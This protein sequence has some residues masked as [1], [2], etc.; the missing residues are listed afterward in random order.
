MH[1]KHSAARVLMVCSLWLLA[2]FSS[3]QAQNEIPRLYSIDPELRSPADAVLPIAQS[4]QEWN[5]TFDSEWIHDRAH[6]WSMSVPGSEGLL[7]EYRAR[8]IFYREY[9][10]GERQWIG[11]LRRAEEPMSENAVGTVVIHQVGGLPFG[12]IRTEHGAFDLYSDSVVGTRLARVGPWLDSGDVAH[13]GEVVPFERSAMGS[14]PKTLQEVSQVD[15]LV[16][17]DTELAANFVAIRNKIIVEKLN[18]DAVFALSG[19]PSSRGVPVSLNLVEIQTLAI[20]D[21]LEAIDQVGNTNPAFRELTN[22]TSAISLELESRLAQSGADLLALFVPFRPET[23]FVEFCGLAGVPEHG[24]QDLFFRNSFSMQS[25][26]CSASQLVFVHELLHNFGSNHE[27]GGAF[28][29]YAHGFSQQEAVA[30]VMGCGIADFPDPATTDCLRALRLSD[31]DDQLAGI[32]LGVPGVRDN[33][34]FLTECTGPEMCRRERVANRGTGTGTGNPPPMVGI[35]QPAENAIFLA[36]GTFVLS[37]SAVDATSVT[38]S[39]VESGSPVVTTLGTRSSPPYS[40]VTNAFAVPGEY[41]V[42]AAA[43]DATGQLTVDTHRVRAIEPSDLSVSASQSPGSSIRWTVQNLG[44]GGTASPFELELHYELSGVQ[45][46]I[47][48]VGLP[49]SCEEIPLPP[50]TSCPSSHCATSFRCTVPSLASGES[51]ELEQR[52]CSEH[53][54]SVPARIEITGLGD[55]VDPNPSNNAIEGIFGPSDQCSGPTPL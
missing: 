13:H 1:I 5:L 34:R 20:P 32:P 23:P 31:P 6:E 16:V 49:S 36:T 55:N 27:L 17:I 43:V 21:P 3:A 12:L 8:R 52:F 46:S 28:E 26:F 54:T 41:L 47:E 2:S 18:A 4:I 10:T 50:G 39:V 25:A 7:E 11:E 33:V 37:A 38:W 51:F 53:T 44:P 15:V 22:G 45:Y 40:L 35:Q 42:S 14:L 30:T 24:F 9:E 19:S 29:D 48:D